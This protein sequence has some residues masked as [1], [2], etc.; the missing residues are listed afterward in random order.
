[1]NGCNWCYSK[2]VFTETGSEAESLPTPDLSVQK[3]YL[4]VYSM[5]LLG[6]RHSFLKTWRQEV[7]W[8]EDI[9][10]VG[11]LVWCSEDKV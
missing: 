6:K 4:Q 8:P 5:V 10:L 1:M 2:T 11:S 3:L 9:R 7:W